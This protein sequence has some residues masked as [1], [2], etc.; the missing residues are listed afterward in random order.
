MPHYPQQDWNES[1]NQASNAIATCSFV[2]RVCMTSKKRR[3]A[4]TCGMSPQPTSTT[5]RKKNEGKEEVRDSYAKRSSTEH[6]THHKTHTHSG[7]RV[8]EQA[9]QN[10]NEFRVLHVNLNNKQSASKTKNENWKNKLKKNNSTRGCWADSCHGVKHKPKRRQG[11]EVSR[12]VHL[13]RGC[14]RGS[15]R[16]INNWGGN[17]RCL[18]VEAHAMHGRGRV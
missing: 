1:T 18:Q 16:F 17:I 4:T 2:W 12:C 3:L 10:E 5:T 15:G 9:N 8:K 13:L 14:W 6:T 11:D 7:K